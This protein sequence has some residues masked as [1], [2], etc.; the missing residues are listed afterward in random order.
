MF[1]VTSLRFPPGRMEKQPR[2]Q[3]HPRQARRAAM[4]KPSSPKET[5]MYTVRFILG[6]EIK[7]GYV[8]FF[9]IL[10]ICL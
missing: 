8:F 9:I 5:K 1:L 4:P 6:E 7:N 3:E 2:A 10:F